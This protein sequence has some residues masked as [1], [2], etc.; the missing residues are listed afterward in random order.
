M[1][2]LVFDDGWFFKHEGA[3]AKKRSSF[4][5]RP[6][7]VGTTLILVFLV[8]FS[9]GKTRRR[10]EAAVDVDV[11][12]YKKMVSLMRWFIKKGETTIREI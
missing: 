12:L 3:N 11:C 2:I 4:G 8:A 1:G 9:Q 5:F 7:L 10:R 6:L